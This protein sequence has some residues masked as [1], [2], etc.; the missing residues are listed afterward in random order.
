M[1]IEPAVFVVPKQAPHTRCSCGA[2]VVVLL[3]GN[4]QWVLVDLARAS[5]D[6]AGRQ[7]APRHECARLSRPT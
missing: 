5:V 6:A 4:R 2:P 7:L 3:D 1:T